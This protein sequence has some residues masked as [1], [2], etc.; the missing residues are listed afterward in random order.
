MG[1]VSMGVQCKKG[2]FFLQTFVTFE[3]AGDCILHVMCHFD[4]FKFTITVIQLAFDHSLDSDYFLTLHV[5][6]H[7]IQ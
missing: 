4:L 5:T 7:Y 1:W 2:I 6:C 3:I